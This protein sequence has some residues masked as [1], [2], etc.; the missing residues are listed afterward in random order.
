MG[1]D[2]IEVPYPYGEVSSDDYADVTADDAADLAFTYDLLQTGGSDC[3]GPD[4]G[5]FRIGQVRVAADHFVALR[6]KAASR[7]PLFTA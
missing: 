7:R 1:L 5:K 2:A 4:S 3:H 6:E